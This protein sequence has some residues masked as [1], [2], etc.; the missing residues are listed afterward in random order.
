MNADPGTQSPGVPSRT[1]FHF[2]INSVTRAAPIVQVL[3]TCV[4]ELEQSGFKYKLLCVL[5]G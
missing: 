1:C 3:R 2:F 4:L 5:A